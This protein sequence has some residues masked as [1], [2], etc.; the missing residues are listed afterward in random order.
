MPYSSDDDMSDTM[1]YYDFDQDGVPQVLQENYLPKHRIVFSYDG[2]KDYERIV[3]YE[4]FTKTEEKFDK[5]VSLIVVNLSYS[6]RTLPNG[7]PN[8]LEIS[9]FPSNLKK[10]VLM[11]DNS[12]ESFNISNLPDT[13]EN[14]D[15]SNCG[16]V[17]LPKLPPNLKQL[18]CY[19]NNIGELEGLPDSLEKLLCFENNMLSMGILPKNLKYLDC[20]Y[21][22]NLTTLPELPE[23][24]EYLNCA[25]TGIYR[26]PKLPP[27]LQELNCGY[28]GI[29]P[30]TCY[31][32]NGALVSTFPKSLK[33]LICNNCCFR[34][35]LLPDNLEYLDC[36]NS[37]QK[38]AMEL[39]KDLNQNTIDFDLNRAI[40][41]MSKTQLFGDFYNVLSYI[42]YPSSLKYVNCSG[43]EFTSFY[44]LPKNLKDYDCSYNE[45]DRYDS[46]AD[47][48][49]GLETLK[50]QGNNIPFKG[51]LGKLPKSLKVFEC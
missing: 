48:P 40:K 47:L 51:R 33:K 3:N 15:C 23:S 39:L 13:L 14:F 20:A 9:K 18:V 22:E 8:K 42:G 34:Q 44:G 29:N 1:C 4:T 41:H 11:T 45:I 16:L 6:D 2:K 26:L 38:D 31:H 35:I 27:N 5:I 30:P 37:L 43:N 49:E 10:L 21:N 28:N 7:Q 24:L 25:K 17:E 50:I 12:N 46:S 32:K 19:Q 36:S